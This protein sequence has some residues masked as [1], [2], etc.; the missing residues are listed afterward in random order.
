M[1]NDVRTP[2]ADW[3]ATSG[4]RELK[5][6]S[7]LS[8]RDYLRRGQSCPTP[9][10]EEDLRQIELDLP[11]TGESIRRFLLPERELGDDKAA[12]G[13]DD[14]GEEEE[15]PAHVMAPFLPVLKNILVAYSVGHADVL[16]FL[17]GNMNSKRDEEE[18]FWVYASV[19]ESLRLT[20]EPCDITIECF[21]KTSSRARPNSTGFKWYQSPPLAPST[22]A[23]LF[24][25]TRYGFLLPPQDCK[26]YYELV[27]R[28][29]V[30]HYPILAKASTSDGVVIGAASVIDVFF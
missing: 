8:Y 30:P 15:L 1:Q 3:Y 7:A 23:C 24:T 10:F 26:L 14:D 28:K 11:R 12:E 25:P 5:K 13:G 16:C 9:H 17:L 21:Q 18:A 20:N 2:R 4:A 19:V 22:R 6:D 29:L 27:V